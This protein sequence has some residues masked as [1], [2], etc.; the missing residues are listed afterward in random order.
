MDKDETEVSLG[1]DHIVL[2]G[3]PALPPQKGH[4]SSPHFRPMSVVANMPLG[5]EVDLSAGDIVL[6]ED[7]APPPKKRGAQHPQFWPILTHVLWPNGCMHQDATWC[8]GRSRPWRHCIRWGQLP[9]E[10]GTTTPLFSAHVYCGQT[11]AY[12]S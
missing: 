12:L 10:K 7:P 5:T 11:V 6:D 9:P 1:P 2:D 3:D 8:G 4:S